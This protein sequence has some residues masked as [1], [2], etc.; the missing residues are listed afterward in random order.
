MSDWSPGPE[1]GTA[2][3][4]NWVT[5]ADAADAA[6]VSPNDVRAWAARGEIVSQKGGETVMVRLDEVLRRA[7]GTE[8]GGA[9]DYQQTGAASVP[10]DPD[11][12]QVNLSPIITSIP[13]LIG[14]VASA[15]DRAARAETKVDF[16]REQMAEM[17]KK[18]EGHEDWTHP[19]EWDVVADADEEEPA[20]AVAAEPE[21]ADEPEAVEEPE[22]QVASGTEIQQAPGSESEPEGLWPE[23]T[24]AP[25]APGSGD[26]PEGWGTSEEESGSPLAQPSLTPESSVPDDLWAPSGGETEKAPST[27]SSGD[28]SFSFGPPAR[29]RRWWQRRR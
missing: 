13:E 11:G 28:K 26:R 2:S 25:Q 21:Q 3:G 6:G 16:L 29:K 4:P 9:G 23:R 19:E 18:L 15:A 14:Q 10:A 12:G 5:A 17:R 27:P 8:G 20:E 22:T 1:S 7:S 24:E